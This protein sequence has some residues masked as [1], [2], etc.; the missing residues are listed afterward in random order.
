MATQRPPTA[1]EKAAIVNAARDYL[2]DPHSVRDA[3]IS[4]ALTLNDKGLVAMCVKAN[5]K[6]PMGGY[7]GRK[8]VSVRLLNGKPVGTIEN[9]PGCFMPVLKYERFTELE[10]L[11]NI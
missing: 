3:E 9:A 7:S 2:I 8:V 5:A 11:K 4:N 10:N 1:S 6:N